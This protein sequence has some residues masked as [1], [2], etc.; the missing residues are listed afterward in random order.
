MR[1]EGRGR[2]TRG[3]LFHRGEGRAYNVSFV[4]SLFKINYVYEG[5]LIQITN[6][7]HK[8]ELLN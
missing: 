5:F 2:G 4:K 1:V 6:I 8:I 3:Q 7:K